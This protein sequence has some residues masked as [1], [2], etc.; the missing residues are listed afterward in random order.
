MICIPFFLTSKIMIIAWRIL[1]IFFDEI[2]DCMIP[3]ETA[4]TVFI[5]LAIYISSFSF[6]HLI[7]FL[8]KVFLI[9][10]WHRMRLH[11]NLNF[12]VWF[13]DFR[14][15]NQVNPQYLNPKIW[16]YNEYWLVPYICAKI[17][18]RKCLIIEFEWIFNLFFWWF[19]QFY[20]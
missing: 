15:K 9:L 20:L 18:S 13:W 7:C 12:S 10:G 5:N 19:F 14:K 1:Q 17:F 2:S 6:T 11:Q 4:F 8:I 16:N 3:T